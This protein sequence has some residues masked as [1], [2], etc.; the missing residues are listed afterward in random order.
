MNVRSG[1][2]D[3]SV[4]WKLQHRVRVVEEHN[5]SNVPSVRNGD[6]D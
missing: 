5:D 4:C 1:D 6:V 2:V 3:D